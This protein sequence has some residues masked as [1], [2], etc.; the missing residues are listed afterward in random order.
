MRAVCLLIIVLLGINAGIGQDI[1]RLELAKKHIDASTEKWGLTASD[2]KNLQISSEA[3]SEKGITYLYLNQAYE[4]IPIQNAMIVMVMDKQGN[5]HSDAHTLVA[6]VRK[7]INAT[8]PKINAENAMLT[9]AAHLGIRLKSTPE[10]SARANGAIQYFEWPEMVKSSIPAQLKYVLVDDK[11]VLVWNLNLDMKAS[12]DYWD[13]NVDATTGNFISKYNYTTYCSHNHDAFANHSRC[14]IKTFR[15]LNENRVNMT[16]AIA[17]GNA[18]ATYN[19]FAIPAESPN[20]GGRQ[21]VTDG[22][23]PDA[24]PFG[25]HDTN[26]AA[27]AEFTTTRGNNVFAYQDKD[28][29]DEP[30]GAATNGGTGLVFDFPIDMSKDPRESS[31][32]SVTN[33]F[34][35]VNMMHDVTHQLGFTEEFGNFQQTN[36]S[37]KGDGGDYV[38]AQAFDGIDLHEAGQTN[39]PKV[40]NANFSTPSD[41]FNGRMQMFFWTN[42]GGS[43]S[44]DA[45]EQIKGFISEYGTGQFGRPIPANNEP[46][47]TAKVALARD[48]SANPTAGCGTIANGNEIAGKIAIM[49]RGLCEFGKKVLN[50]QQAGAVAA[51]ICNIV[52]VNGGNGEEILGMAAGASGGSVSIPSIFLKKSDCDKIR[53]IIE[54]GGEVTMTFQERERQGAEYLDGSLDNGII[55]HEFGHGI[56]I[57]LTGGRLNS[58]CL[59]NDEQMGEGW[60]D[61][62]S[63]IMTHEPGDK[64]EDVRGIGTFATAQQ[65][66][67][68]GIRRYPY[69]VDLSVNPQTFDDIKGTTAPHPLGEVWAGVLWDMYWEFIKLYGYDPDWKN[70]GSGNYKAVYLVMEGMKMQPCNPG[71]IQGRDAILKADQVHNNGEHKCLIWQ[72]FARR[73]LGFYANGGVTTDRNDGTEDFEPL[74]TCI[75][76]LKISKTATASINAGDEVTVTLKAINHIPS[77]QNNVIITDELPAGMTYVNG[78]SNIAPVVTGNML[79]FEVGDMEYERELVITY[80]TKS[81]INNKSVRLVFENFDGSFEWDIEKEEG[82]EDWLPTSDL[83]RSP[84]TS[85]NIINVA[86]E[87]DASLRSIPYQITGNN[88]AMRFWHRYNT[89]NGNDGG[90]VEVS[91]NNGAY[92]PV[93]KEQFIRNGYNGPLSYSTLAIPALDA[94]SGN[95]G[96]NWSATSNVGPWIDSYIDMSPYKGQTVTFRFRF[97]SDATTVAA[98]DLKGWYIDDFELLDIYKYSSEACIA[99]DN[100]QGEKACTQPVETLVNSEVISSNED[101]VEDY[102]EAIIEPNPANDYLSVHVKAPVRSQAVIEILNSGG[103]SVYNT[104]VQLT[105]SFSS[106][107]IDTSVFPAGMYFVRIKDGKKTT[108]KKLILQ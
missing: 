106:T 80:K 95:S 23:Y 18:P 70:T 28:D 86:A 34:Y 32:A 54:N 89:Q 49:D 26:G 94:F 42:E 51:I 19:V 47:I 59:N 82:S 87:S 2:V 6:D 41:G 40:N 105:E 77:R 38:L 9:A 67:G 93:K 76:K 13:L 68:G 5:V 44:I 52:G 83:F 10:K 91:V 27:G 69:S 35:M 31:D 88:P 81:S 75:E 71:F 74:P 96:G 78:S 56:S 98:G 29:N 65:V 101:V 63:L 14:E 3:T 79:T 43:V 30:D 12:A 102:F 55:A 73:G 22:Q 107:F 8:A 85:F 21:I 99:A 39:P 36:Y 92:T 37:N 84:E 62:F 15:K 64:P 7:K 1:S 57:R 46:P 60:S 20:H 72:V 50:A 58:S 90:F 25:W 66:T 24:S 11:L 16:E 100:G 103:S 33:L 4:N 17:S 97:G 53:V 61:F 45:P 108:V 104:K 48:N